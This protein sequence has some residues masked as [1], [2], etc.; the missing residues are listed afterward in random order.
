M[1][2]SREEKIKIQIDNNNCIISGIKTSKTNSNISTNTKTKASS[3]KKFQKN[4]HNNLYNEISLSISNSLEKD[5]N[6]NDLSMMEITEKSIFSSEMKNGSFN[7]NKGSE[8]KKEKKIRKIKDIVGRKL[9]FDFVKSNKN[10]MSNISKIKNKRLNKSHLLNKII[11]DYNHK[12]L[13]KKMHNNLITRRITKKIKI[14]LNFKEINLRKNHSF[15]ENKKSFHEKYLSI[16]N[17]TYKDNYI[18]NVDSP[19]KSNCNISFN[20]ISGNSRDEKNI[21]I[22]LKARKKIINKKSSDNNKA[23]KKI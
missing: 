4:M 7:N 5:A 12:P 19:K 20:N 18:K 17:N 11:L 3:L 10:Y 1:E 9:I 15:R 16:N 14:N 23:G 22:N 21:N 8:K 2:F 13:E 6:N